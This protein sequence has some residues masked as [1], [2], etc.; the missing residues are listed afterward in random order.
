MIGALAM[1]AAIGLAIFLIALLAA[2]VWI[3]EQLLFP[4][5]EDR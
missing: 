3:V 1:L 5:E 2:V 4:W